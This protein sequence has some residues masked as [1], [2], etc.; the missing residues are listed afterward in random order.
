LAVFRREQGDVLVSWL[1]I[2]ADLAYS[3]GY[4]IA[5]DK[6]AYYLLAFI[7]FTIAA[8]FAQNGSLA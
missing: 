6:D 8:G 1:V 2:A 4:E 3:L 5:E 7:A